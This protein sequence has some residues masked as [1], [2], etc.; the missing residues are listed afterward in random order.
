MDV[1]S[2]PLHELQEQANQLADRC[3]S[4]AA[5]GDDAGDAAAFEQ[6]L[7]LLNELE[8]RTTW[9]DPPMAIIDPHLK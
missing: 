7:P 2:I 8:R 3:R 1:Q 4:C 5:T 9:I 6:L